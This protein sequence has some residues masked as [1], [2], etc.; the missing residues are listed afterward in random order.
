M[1][2]GISAIQLSAGFN[3]QPVSAAVNAPGSTYNCAAEIAAVEPLYQLGLVT[4][5]GSISLT[6]PSQLVLL[7]GVT[8][9]LSG[10]SVNGSPADQGNRLAVVLIDQTGTL[11]ATQE[12]EATITSDGPNIL[13]LNGTPADVSAELATLTLDEAVGGPDSV[14]VEV[15]G[16]TGLVTEGT[17]SVLATNPNGSATYTPNGD[18]ATPQLWDQATAQVNNGVVVQETMTW[19]ATDG[20]SSAALIGGA[21]I[22]PIVQVAVDQPLLEEGLTAPGAVA[23]LP[24]IILDWHTVW[25]VYDPLDPELET[26]AETVPVTETA[27]TLMFS[28]STGNL[29]EEVDTL[30][31]VPSSAYTNL[32]PFLSTN[33]PFYFA[34]GGLAI[35]LYDLA[36]NPYWTTT[37]YDN[38]AGGISEIS[39]G[40][41][42]VIADG[43]TTSM[44]VGSVDTIYGIVNG[45]DK[46][47]EVRYLGAA[48]DPY[49]EVDQIFN[50]YSA[51]PQLWQQ[52][53]T[54]GIPTPM[55]GGSLLTVPSATTVIEFNTGN[56]P[57]WSNTIWTDVGGDLETVSVAGDLEVATTFEA[58]NWDAQAEIS[59]SSVA[60]V[61]RGVTWIGEGEILSAYNLP[62]PAITA[63]TS[64]DSISGTGIAGDWIVVTGSD[65]QTLGGAEVGGSGTWIV[66][67]SAAFTPSGNYAVTAQ[68]FDLAGDSSSASASFSINSGIVLSNETI[69]GSPG[70][71][72]SVAGQNITVIGSG[73]SISATGLLT[74]VA[75]SGTG[76]TV[77]AVAG[78]FINDI[79]TT[80]TLNLVAS[81]ATLAAS[82][83]DMINQQGTNDTLSFANGGTL[84]LGGTTSAIVSGNSV[85]A[86]MNMSG[87]ALSV[88]GPNNIITGGAN[89]TVTIDGNYNTASISDGGTVNVNGQN[90]GIIGSGLSIAATGSLTSFW[91]SGTNDTVSLTSGGSLVNV[92]GLATIG[93]ISGSN[94]LTVATNSFTSQT[95]SGFSVAGHDQIDLSNYL[96]GLPTNSADL[97]RYIGVT[98]VGSSTV[99]AITGPAGTDTVTL[100][101][102][103]ALSLQQL[104]NGNTFI[105]PSG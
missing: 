39:S 56:N 48:S 101:G 42:M 34:D 65:G 87:D 57:N 67:P 3:A 63:W 105:Y 15:F 49:D 72:V 52:V 27:S 78:T 55:T 14:A 104:I 9:A 22:M 29:E 66:A 54:V 100:S 47:I 95:V 82:T 7:Q 70:T 10:V 11:S 93:F 24:S 41:T 75:I 84:G 37:F 33:E 62:S 26:T 8:I 88:A 60:T 103:G 16:N 20:L 13:I 71:V 64:T 76:N 35:T 90:S 94:S 69:I 77:S 51:T 99:L 61:Q 45:A 21:I 83:G 59:A 81:G 18:S 32:F 86:W 73:L 25:Q 102:A 1:T 96:R 98:D 12:G 4:T 2:L 6:L 43:S 38:G 89:E 30:A 58:G 97:S 40:S 5:A 28:A 46:V 44:A 85:V 50:P 53:E 19:N 31:A 23:S 80:T 79:G 68:Q 17:I 36:N 74:S 91:V 92:F